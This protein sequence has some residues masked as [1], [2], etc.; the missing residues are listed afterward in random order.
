MKGG[1]HV[2]AVVVVDG[3]DRVN[4]VLVPVYD[5]LGLAW[6]P[7][8]TGSVA[9]E[10]PGMTWDAVAE[11]LVGAF[12]ERHALEPAKLD[13]GTIALARRLA[14]EHLAAGDVALRG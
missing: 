9:G 2:G 12:A 6:R 5:A 8:A 10:V 14:P 11:A 3:A 7:Q 13:D 4:D 1:A